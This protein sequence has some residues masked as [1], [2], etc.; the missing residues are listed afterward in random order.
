VARPEAL[1]TTTP[2]PG[3][4]CNVLADRFAA[5]L[6]AL[7]GVVH[8]ASNDTE[9]GDIVRDLA[10]IESATRILSW[11]PDTLTCPG[12]VAAL[13]RAGIALVA[14]ALPDDP[15]RRRAV[16]ADLDAI[17]IGLTGAVAGLAD[18]GSIVVAR[19]TGP[20]PRRTRCGARCGAGPVQMDGSPSSVGVGASSTAAGTGAGSNAGSS[21][22]SMRRKARRSAVRSRVCWPWKRCCARMA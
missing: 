19:G 9:A 10:R 20:T 5:E 12:V 14:P 22:R 8:R 13:T 7:T 21:S 17:P 6:E 4:G 2:P 11:E 18:T 1:V 16:L 15:G 3:A